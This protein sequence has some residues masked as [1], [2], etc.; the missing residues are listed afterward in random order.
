MGK[1]KSTLLKIFS[2][3]RPY[4]NLVILMLVFLFVQVFGMLY[5]PTL[6]ADIVDNGIIQGDL[7]HI[8]NIG[9]LMILV[10][11]LVAGVSILSTYLSSSIA[12]SLG[13]DIRNALFRKV[14][15]LSIDEF[16]QFGTA[17]MITRNTSDIIQIQQA[18][19]SSIQMLL[20]APFMA[21]AGLI[22]AFSKDVILALSIIGAMGIVILLAILI[23][24]KAIPLL[25]KQQILFDDMNS[26]V[27]EK[28]SGVRVI[29]AFNRMDHEKARMNETFSN[30]SNTAIKIN[31][32]F[33][34]LMPLITLVMNLSTLL[35]VWLGDIRITT[36]SMQLGDIIA[37]IGYASIILT[38]LIMG[39]MG[40]IGLPKAKISGD[41]IT[42]VLNAEEGISKEI[43]YNE[44]PNSD[45]IIEFNHVTFG[46][47]DA[48]EPV[49]QDI[50]FKVKKG[51]TTAIIGST[52]SGKTTIVNL[53]MGFYQS[54]K[55]NVF[56]KGIDVNNLS[57]DLLRKKIGYVPQKAFL[58]S[59]TIS[60][61]LRYGKKDA[62]ADEMNHACHIAQIS[63]FIDGL[64]D[65]LE[66]PVSQGGNNFSGGQKQ[67]LSI[68]RAV[69]K[70]PDLYVF[71][72]SFSA[73]D[74]KTDAKLRALLS[75]ETR[76]A[77]VIIV[78]QRVNTIMSA[79]QIIVLDQGTI[80]GIG[81]HQTLLAECEPYQQIVESQL[82]K[83]ELA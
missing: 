59:G 44:Q 61:N 68:A 6:T 23:S 71:D 4:R 67:R 25:A 17:S 20:P 31:K 42:A 10:A 18:F 54:N 64:K 11:A 24:K 15:R 27:R 52:G 66:T 70:K 48:E 75:T 2:F 37:I 74:F 82:G 49:L 81:T 51:Q 69:I 77:A 60:D 12:A 47:K 46:Y 65:Q 56:Y 34:T 38:S 28:I 32:L 78:A 41:R 21:I 80:V 45:T 39:I 26:K 62:T 7:N 36:G 73:L 50:S 30:Y 57:E 76:D 33:A 19:L 16:N 79:E 40:I 72:D 35:I 3:L 9:T 14:Q 1:N 22:L 53:L 43:P 5:I 63:D 8:W 83:E 55:G 58:F 13:R 29:R